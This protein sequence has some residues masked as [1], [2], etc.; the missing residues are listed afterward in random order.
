MDKLIELKDYGIVLKQ[1]KLCNELRSCKWIENR[2]DGCDIMYP[3]SE[4]TC[5]KPE[6]TCTIDENTCPI[7]DL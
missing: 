5:P 2:F 1:R 4:N 3:I 7:N 6:N